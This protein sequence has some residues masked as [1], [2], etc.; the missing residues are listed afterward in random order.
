M[1]KSY[2]HY[3]FLSDTPSE[4]KISLSIEPIIEFPFLIEWEFTL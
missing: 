3:L 4:S 2:Q 1:E